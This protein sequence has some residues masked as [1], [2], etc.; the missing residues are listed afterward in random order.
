MLSNHIIAGRE[1]CLNCFLLQRIL[2]L[3]HFQFDSGLSDNPVPDVT[4]NKQTFK[5]LESDRAI[6]A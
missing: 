2:F 5:P 4:D 6:I 1:T 3:E